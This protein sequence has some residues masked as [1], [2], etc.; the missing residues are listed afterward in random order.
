MDPLNIVR[1]QHMSW[2]KHKPPKYPP[3]PKKPIPENKEPKK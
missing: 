2:Y 3:L 1:R